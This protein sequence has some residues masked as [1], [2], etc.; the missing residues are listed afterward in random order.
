MISLRIFPL[1]T[2][3]SVGI[4]NETGQ[5]AAVPFMQD[6]EQLTGKEAGTPRCRSSSTY[7]MP[8]SVVLDTIT[9]RLGCEAASSTPS[10]S[11][12]DCK[13]RLIEAFIRC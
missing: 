4:D 1:S 2:I 6:G 7:C 5:L 3:S 10:H 9:S 11:A 12:F 13:T 8:T